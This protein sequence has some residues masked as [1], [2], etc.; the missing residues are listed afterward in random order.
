LLARLVDIKQ[1]ESHG[2][3]APFSSADV[4]ALFVL[5]TPTRRASTANA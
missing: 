1:Q 4:R 5:Q 2:V 3:P